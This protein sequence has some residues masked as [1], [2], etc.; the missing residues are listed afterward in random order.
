[1]PEDVEVLAVQLPG[2]ESMLFDPPHETI[3]D[4]VSAVAALLVDEPD[5]PFAFYGHSMGSLI[6]YELTLRLEAAGAAAPKCLFVSSRRPPDVPSSDQAIHDLPD[7]EFVDALRERYGG[8]PEE[9]V[10]EPELLRLVL[11]AIRADLRALETYRPAPGRRI[12]CPIRAY[13]GVHDLRPT[14][15]ELR[16]W[17]RLSTEPLTVRLFDGGHFFI[18][19][20][21]E[22]LLR[23]VVDTLGRAAERARPIADAD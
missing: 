5:T 20:H 17:E 12:R 13:G 19:D 22:A 4:M 15:D 21:R 23:D 11:P 6:G 7:R 18:A 8:L 10:R 9:V 1:V 14:P 2:R 3:D 16:G